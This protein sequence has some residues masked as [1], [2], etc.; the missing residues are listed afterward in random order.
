VPLD[1]YD[2]AG[3]LAS[4]E[5][6]NALAPADRG[7]GRGGSPASVDG[8]S[9]DGGSADGGSADG[10]AVTTVQGASVDGVLTTLAGILAVDPPSVA[11]LS[12][13][14]VPGFTAL[15]QQLRRVFDHLAGGDIDGAARRLNDLLADHPA[16]PHLAREQGRWRLHH[17]PV[18]VALVPMW[19]SI[20]AEG[21]ARTMGTGQQDRLGT[22]AAP[23]CGRVFVDLSKNASRRFCSTTC[24]NRVKA[25]AFRRRMKA[26]PP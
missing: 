23:D 10:G 5:L 4:V 19:T 11:L 1:S 2:N 8:G 6:V 24:Q 26:A 3:V 18:D 20:C 21:M 15:A 12:Q 14:D 13:D 7:G 9:A 25:A 22:C 16:H 17:H